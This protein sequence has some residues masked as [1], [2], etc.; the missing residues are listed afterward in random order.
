MNVFIIAAGFTRAAFPAAPLNSE[1]LDRLANRRPNSVAPIL[2]DRYATDAFSVNQT[3]LRC[4]KPGALGEE[5]F[6]LR[7][8]IEKELGDY[9]DTEGSKRANTVP[10]S[11]TQPSENLALGVW[12]GFGMGN[13]YQE[14][15]FTAA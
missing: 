4:S 10:R 8:R 9:P 6:R 15:D 5:S 12:S 2:R 13:D 3:R 1:L 11:M 7:L 14:W